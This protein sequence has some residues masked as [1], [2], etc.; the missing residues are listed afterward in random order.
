MELIY[1]KSVSGRPGVRLPARDIPPAAPLPG[2]FLR[3]EPANLPEASELD[4]VR[5]FTLLSRRNVGVD[6]HFYPLGSCTMKYNGKAME[7]GAKL[8]APF[9]PMTALLP[10]GEAVSQGSLAVLHHMGRA[11]AEI[12]G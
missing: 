2:G 6:T 9:H 7:E 12:T 10:G 11:L 4:V 1:E 3:A 8:F 5:H